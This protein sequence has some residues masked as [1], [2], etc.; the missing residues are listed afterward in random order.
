MG[1]V[2]DKYGE[3]V[4]AFV[5]PVVGAAIDE[6]ELFTYARQRLAPHKTP[7]RWIAVHEFPLTGSGK[8]QRYVLRQRWEG[9]LDLR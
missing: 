4:G 3:T 9:G 5:R 1:H 2:D 6:A 7:K 8:I